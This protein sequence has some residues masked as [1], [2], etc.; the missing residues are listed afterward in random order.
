MANAD[1]VLVNARA[2]ADRL[3]TEAKTAWQAAKDAEWAAVRQAQATAKAQAR[4]EAMAAQAETAKASAEA[5]ERDFN[6]RLGAI[7]KA[8]GVATVSQP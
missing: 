3:E 7:L 2:T 5:A 4:L 8:A 1:N 6:E